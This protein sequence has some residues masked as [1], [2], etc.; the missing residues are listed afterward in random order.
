MKEGCGVH[1]D[2]GDVRSRT[3][4]RL[5]L[6][7]VGVG[8]GAVAG[9][10][11]LQRTSHHQH[12]SQADHLVI[13]DNSGNTEMVVGGLWEVTVSFHSF[14]LSAKLSIMSRNAKKFLDEGESPFIFLKLSHYDGKIQ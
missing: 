1:L 10:N 3:K 13:S 12:N 6:E 4:V 8:V 5:M 9:V 11:Q 2:P 7:D 14:Y